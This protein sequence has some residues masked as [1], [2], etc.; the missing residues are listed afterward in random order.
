M[1]EKMR[2]LHKLESTNIIDNYDGNNT[3]YANNK[4]NVC[5]NSTKW[6][7]DFMESPYTLAD[8][9]QQHNDNISPAFNTEGPSKDTEFIRSLLTSSSPTKDNDGAD[10]VKILSYGRV[11]I[12]K[13]INKNIKNLN[14]NDLFKNEVNLMAKRTDVNLFDEQYFKLDLNTDGH[15]KSIKNIKKNDSDDV[16]DDKSVSKK[17]NKLSVNNHDD[18]NSHHL[19]LNNFIEQQYFGSLQQNSNKC[20]DLGDSSSPMSPPPSPSF[21]APSQSASSL[22]SFINQQTHLQFSNYCS[23][24]NGKP[25]SI[26]NKIFSH[27][28]TDKVYIKTTKIPDG[29]CNILNFFD[30]QF[31]T[32]QRTNEETSRDNSTGQFLPNSLTGTPYLDEFSNRTETTKIETLTRRQLKKLVSE[33]V[34]IEN[35]VTAYDA[36]VKMKIERKKQK[37]EKMNEDDLVTPSRAKNWTGPVDS[38]GFKILKDQVKRDVQHMIDSDL[39]SMLCDSIL[40]ENEQVIIIDKPYGLPTHGGPGVDKSVSSLL[41]IMA[42]RREKF[43]KSYKLVHRLD[44]ETTGVMVLAKTEQVADILMGMFKKRQVIKT[45]WLITRGVPKPPQGQIDIPLAEGTVG[46]RYRMELRPRYSDEMKLLKKSAPNFDK[47]DVKEAITNYR[48]LDSSDSC[49]LVECTPESGV[50]HQIR[51]HMAFALNTPI[52]G[53]PKYSH[54]SKIAPQ[55]LPPSMLEKLGIRQA[56]VRHL[57][58]HLHA[59]SLVL[60]EFLPNGNNLFVS[61]RL[62][63]FFVQNMKWLKLII[64]K[65]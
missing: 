57:A 2:N 25:N 63:Q 28:T 34:N 41:D 24:N 39:V 5:Q 52:L 7:N 44:K 33:K 36:L 50:K 49:A 48:V 43:L 62:P 58:M 9:G 4:G 64:P 17:D 29:N 11:R 14:N 23:S 15:E 22:E 13:P 19:H 26:N 18:D 47:D 61:A 31:F 55:K 45:Y 16:N 42:N 51:C 8:G 6:N 56:K 65:K 53:D 21:S 37:E 30:E 46:N 20:N 10:N 60:P 54:F 40:F 1:R 59:R 12:D 38:K 27:E 32:D 35:P 3:N